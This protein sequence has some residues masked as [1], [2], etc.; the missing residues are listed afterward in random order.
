MTMQSLSAKEWQ[1]WI[2]H[3][4]HISKSKVYKNSNGTLIGETNSWRNPLNQEAKHLDYYSKKQN[5]TSNKT[6]QVI[7]E[8]CFVH[9]YKLDKPETSDFTSYSK[10]YYIVLND[11]FKF[12][13]WLSRGKWHAMELV[14]E[15]ASYEKAYSKCFG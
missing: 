8:V 15:Y 6:F 5:T 10:H 3:F 1:V 12:E 13:V 4:L 7:N 11:H 9:N 14:G 2:H